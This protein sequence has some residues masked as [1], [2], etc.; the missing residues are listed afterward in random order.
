M[1]F[2]SSK[3]EK[4]IDLSYADLAPVYEPMHKETFEEQN[5]AMD[6]QQLKNQ[7]NSINLVFGIC[8]WF[9]EILLYTKCLTFCALNSL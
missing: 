2:L 5:I 3:N 8:Y 6:D 4:V 1:R 7:Q 9:F